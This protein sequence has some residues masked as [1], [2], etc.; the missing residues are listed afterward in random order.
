MLWIKRKGEVKKQAIAAGKSADEVKVILEEAK[1]EFFANTERPSTST[2]APATA[3]PIDPAGISDQNHTVEEQQGHTRGAY[4]AMSDLQYVVKQGSRMGYHFM[5]FLNSY[6]D[7]K[8][9]GMKLDWFRH[10]M[11]FQIS[12]DDSRELFGNKS[13]SGLPEHI[14]QYYDTLNRHSFRPY[15]HH[16]ICWDGWIV[17]DN[18]EAVNPFAPSNT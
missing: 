2:L 18:G 7:L 16:G 3:T 9:T 6:A 12:A 5:L 1:K 8:A 4:N 15:L 14:C 11:S 13:A 10:R 17:D